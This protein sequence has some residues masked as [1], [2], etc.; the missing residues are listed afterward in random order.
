[1]TEPKLVPPILDLIQDA[2][3][4]VGDAWKPADGADPYDLSQ[5][6]NGRGVLSVRSL[7]RSVVSAV[8][9]LKRVYERLE[10][11]EDRVSRLEK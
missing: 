2:V 7:H 10:Q 8:T 11:L 5:R 4:Y 6:N 9:A 1:M 3:K